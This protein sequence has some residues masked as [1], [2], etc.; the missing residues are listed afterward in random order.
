[1]TGLLRAMLR[2]EFRLHARLF[3]GV[4]FAL[5]PAFVAALTVGALYGLDLTGTDTG[6]VLAG[7]HALVALFGVQTGL[8]GLLSADALDDLLGDVTL[9]VSAARTLPVSE[10]RV[11]A[12]FLLKDA[13]YYSGLFVLPLS[14][15]VGGYALATGD[16]ALAATAPRLATTL[17]ATF[18][19]GLS[20]TL[21]LVG[22]VRRGTVGKAAVVL[23][24]AA[25]TA[26]YLSG[27]SLWTWTPY[28]AYV[29]PTSPRV[30]AVLSVVL[31][32]AVAGW[33]SFDPTYR[34][35]ERRVEARFAW[36]ADRLPA[37]PHGLAARSLLELH[38]SG[39]GLLKVV[40]SAGL[41]SGFAVAVLDLAATITGRTPD[42]AVTLG[43]LLGL[44]A[45]TTYNWLTQFDSLEGYRVHPLSVADVFRAKLVGFCVLLPVGG[46]FYLGAAVLLG[47]SPASLALGGVLYAGLSLYLFGLTVYLTGVEPNEFLFD[48]FL[49]ALFTAGAALALVPV[50]VV[51]LV[52]PVSPGLT[53]GLVVLAAVLGVLGYGLVGRAAPRWEAHLLHG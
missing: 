53:G 40:L 13:V 46:A 29:A 42:A 28:G 38:R 51:G 44:T 17:A 25:G 37:D 6:T 50:L 19:L 41:V 22:T 4:R 45:F 12:V 2:E 18:V 32:F 1:M 35:P 31:G 16:G 8:V 15:A 3:G 47:G 11:Y 52:V 7:L 10:R 20:G 23:A 49:F 9:L 34:R 39:G 14:F 33:W 30:G 36:L 43:A 48:S 27:H 26:V 24:V 5:F 21:T